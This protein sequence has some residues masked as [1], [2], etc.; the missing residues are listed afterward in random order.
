[1]KDG[2]LKFTTLIT[3]ITRKIRRI[4]SE[5]VAQYEIKRSYALPL[6]FLYKNGPQSAAKLTKLCAEDKANVSRTLRALEDDGYIVREERAGARSRVRFA[7]SEEGMEIGGYLARRMVEAVRGA[8]DGI[9]LDELEVMYSVLGR[10]DANLAE[11][12]DKSN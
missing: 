1:M 10:I 6:Y 11:L 8:T 2:F 7:L 4:I 9:G 3:D 5:T 12:F